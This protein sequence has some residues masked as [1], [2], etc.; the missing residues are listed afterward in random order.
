MVELLDR[1]PEV[2]FTTLEAEIA[3][4]TWG[5]NC[6]PGAFCA[7]LGLRPEQ[8]RPHFKGFEDK[9]YT[10][11]TMMFEALKSYGAWFNTQS[12]P[13]GSM[14]PWPKHGLVRIQWGGP[15]MKDGVPM[16]ARYRQTHWVA[17]W[18]S[19]LGTLAIFDINAIESGGWLNQGPWENDIVPW[20][21]KECVPRADGT[22]CMTH[23]I[24]L[25]RLPPAPGKAA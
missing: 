4:D 22:W 23:A 3:G 7:A 6:G 11:P 17:S 20:L 19:T 2:R 8:A 16:Q 1:P 5:F 13:R 25:M 18:V 12:A 15:W 14:L 9:G 24:N 21:L 10:N